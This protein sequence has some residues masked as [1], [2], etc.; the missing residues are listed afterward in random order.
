MQNSEFSIHEFAKY[1]PQ[2][3]FWIRTFMKFQCNW[4]LVPG[5]AAGH[6]I[7]FKL[8]VVCRCTESRK[9]NSVVSRENNSYQLRLGYGFTE[10]NSLPSIISNR[11]YPNCNLFKLR[12]CTLQVLQYSRPKTLVKFR[13]QLPV[14]IHD[15]HFK[16]IYSITFLSVGT[17]KLFV[18]KLVLVLLPIFS[19]SY[20]E[21]FVPCIVLTALLPLLDCS[22]IIHYVI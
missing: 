8:K 21:I 18:A 20:E 11:L 12:T 17:L 2:F 3:Y 22:G 7:I 14:M 1:C 6:I 4:K 13:F 9:R 19:N 16:S 15:S 10:R 5:E